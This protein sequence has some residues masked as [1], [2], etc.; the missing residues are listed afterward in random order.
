M[1]T[2]IQELTPYEKQLIKV[3]LEKDGVVEIEVLLKIPV[4]PRTP[5]EIRNRIAVNMSHLRS[6]GFEIESVRGVGYQLK[7]I[8]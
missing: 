5:K 3:L 6:K 1:Q 8:K 4:P 7:K 2:E